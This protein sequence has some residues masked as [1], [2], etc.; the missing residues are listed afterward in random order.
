MSRSFTFLVNRTSGGGSAAGAVIPVARLLREAG[1]GVEVSYSPGPRATLETIGHA[2]AVG[3]V[4]VAVGGDGTL[5]SMAGE[6]A[7]LGGILGILPSGRGNDFAR[8][9]GLGCEPEAIAATLLTAEPSATDLITTTLADGSRRIIVGSLYAGVD[10]QTADLVNRI[11]WLPRVLHYPAAALYSLATFSPSS[12][13]VDI[14]GVE[15]RYEAACVVVANSG[16]YGSGMH[17]APS[18]HIDDGELDVVVIEATGRLDMLRAFPRIYGG[19]HVKLGHVHVLRGRHVTLTADPT[20]PL[21]GDGE[22]LG[23][24]GSAPLRAEV[25]P[26]ALQLLR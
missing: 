5:S 13:T 16:Y 14:D 22:P 15:R 7:R 25:S 6:V 19:S 2:V 1:A 11:N 21:G 18:A 20:V 8:M 17:V 3:S 4:V 9:I 12:F 23:L 10:A 26:G 24:L